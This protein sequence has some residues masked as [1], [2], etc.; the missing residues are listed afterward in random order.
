MDYPIKVTRLF[1]QRITAH[2]QAISKGILPI[3]DRGKFLRRK[4]SGA[5][6]PGRIPRRTAPLKPAVEPRFS[7]W[8]SGH[9]SGCPT[10][11]YDHRWDCKS[12]FFRRSDDERFEGRS[13]IRFNSWD[14]FRTI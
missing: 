13:F 8:L 9:R 7:I 4:T 6:T 1:L 12:L 5:P 2:R 14:T 3:F 10:W 11:K